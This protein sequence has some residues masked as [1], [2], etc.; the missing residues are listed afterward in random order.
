[1]SCRSALCQ[2]VCG[3]LGEPGQ[4]DAPQ[5]RHLSPH[6]SHRPCHVT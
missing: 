2:S 1:M 5:R 6:R 3:Q 4:S